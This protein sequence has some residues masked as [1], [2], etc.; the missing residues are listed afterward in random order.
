MKESGSSPV[1]RAFLILVAASMA[2]CVEVSAAGFLEER[3]KEFS[4]DNGMKILVLNRPGSPTYAAYVRFLTGAV[5]EKTGETGIAHI[6]EHM[7]FKGTR[8]IGT[9]DFAAEKR[10]MDEVEALGSRLDAENIKGE[11]ADPDVIAD[12]AERLKAKQAEQHEYARKDEMADIYSRN[13]SSGFNA[14]TSMDTTTYLVKLPANK[15]ELWAW[16][17]SDRLRSPVLREYYLE[18]DVVMEERRRSVENSPEGILYERFKAAAFIAHPYGNPIIGW[19]SDI[20]FLPKESVR[21]FLKTYYAPNNMIVAVVGDVD[22]DYVH[23]T[24]RRYFSDIPAQEIPPR[25]ATKEPPQKGERRIEVTMDANPS[26]MTGF[27]KPSM[28]HKDD[29]VFDVIDSVLTSGRTSR[30][31]KSLVLEKRLAASIGSFAAGGNRY[32]NVYGF[33][34]APRAPHTA[35]EVEEAIYEELDRLK[36]EPVS[37]YELQKVINNMEADHIRKLRSNSGLAYYLSYYQ[38]I[39]G[40]WRYMTR[41]LDEIRKVT[42][43]D[44]TAAARKYFVKSN[45]TVATLVPEK[46]SGVDE[47]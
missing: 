3:V 21:N 2:W 27:H 31:Y 1:I 30:L 46:V 32:D 12:L 13:G 16:M 7:L 10:L 29:Y 45:R 14:F 8:R 15:F 35:R 25:I 42:P 44:V 20:E 41:Y 5:D 38:V 26:V 24:I 28:P 36:S 17:E 6:L 34:A 47:N 4:L 33:H 43:D 18:R 37:G 9:K 23:E 39:S 22:P 19:E 11:K 40:D